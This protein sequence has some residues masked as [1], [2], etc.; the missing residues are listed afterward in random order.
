MFS[1][2]F[3]A[4]VG[5]RL[6]TWILIRHSEQ[7]APLLSKATEIGRVFSAPLAPESPHHLG[8]VNL[9]SI[10][11]SVR[12]TSNDSGALDLCR[13]SRQPRV[14]RNSSGLLVFVIKVEP[15]TNCKIHA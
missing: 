6:I 7:F 3:T 9:S 13:V 15:V 11:D 5:P 10:Q 12:V 2:V 14:Y 1:Y 4:F 8:Y